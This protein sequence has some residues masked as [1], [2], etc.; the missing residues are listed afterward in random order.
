VADGVFSPDI[1]KDLNILLDDDV[2]DEGPRIDF[3]VKPLKL[4]ANALGND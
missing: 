4:T 2:L 3:A 1:E